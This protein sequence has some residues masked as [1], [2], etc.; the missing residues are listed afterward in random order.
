MSGG[1]PKEVVMWIHSDKDANWETGE[2]LGLTGEALQL[3]RHALTEVRVVLNV[4]QDGTYK[5]KGVRE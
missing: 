5:I 2:R 1:W 3:F 4:N